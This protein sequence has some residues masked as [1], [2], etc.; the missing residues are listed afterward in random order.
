MIK[1][2][3]VVLVAQGELYPL[4]QELGSDRQ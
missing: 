2:S 4:E 1:R 3:G